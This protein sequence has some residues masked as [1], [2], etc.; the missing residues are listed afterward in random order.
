MRTAEATTKVLIADDSAVFRKLVEQ[1]LEKKPYS[2]LFARNGQEAMD[3]FARHNPDLVI[4]DW[5]MPDLSGIEL[6]QYIRR[7]AQESYTYVILLTG[8]TDKENTV[9]GLTAG[10]DDYLTKPFHPEELIAR[11]AVGRRIVGLQ[12]QVQSKNVLLQELALTDDLTGLPNRR[13][14]EEW[15]RRQLNAAVRHRFSFCVA[16]CDIDHFKLVNDTYG[17]E[18]GDSVLKSFGEILKST[19]RRSDICGRIGG[20]EFICIFTH[21]PLDNARLVVERIRKYLE[22]TAF[23]FDGRKVTVTASFGIADLGPNGPP[24]FHPLLAQADKA[25]YSAKR[26]G[27]NRVE[28]A[29]PNYS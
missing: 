13:A 27:R 3:I 9:A 26:R 6:C 20:E 11:T 12:R 17:H 25:L 23:F 2:L 8:K 18:A 29:G 22:Q 21:I 28:T 1:T 7:T 15:A 4:A 14:V 10:A 19:S 5:V 24:D 16:M